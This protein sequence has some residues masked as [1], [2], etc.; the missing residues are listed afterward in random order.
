MAAY[1]ITYNEP[2]VSQTL[3]QSL[4]DSGVLIQDAVLTAQGRVE[5]R[6]SE[7]DVF[8]L[9]NGTKFR[10]TGT[11]EGMQPEI[12]GESFGMIIQAW[13]KHPRSCYSCK[14]HGSPSLEILVRPSVE[15]ENT[16]E[17]LVAMGEMVVHDFDEN[18]QYF[19][20][21]NLRQGE[22]AYVTYNPEVPTGPTR[23]TA[24]VRQITDEDWSYI[25][26]T[27]GDHRDWMWK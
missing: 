18:G 4:S 12:D 20:I 25:L 2:S 9:Q 26:T 8:R 11:P 1:R 6:S 7:G 15:T 16:D 3:S 27:Y 14:M 23:Y 24:E 19:V 10:L 17:Y 13:P 21:C 22:K 5:L